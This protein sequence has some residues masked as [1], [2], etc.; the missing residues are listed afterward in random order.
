MPEENS[1]PNRLI[2]GIGISLL[3]AIIIALGGWI[4]H[5]EG[6]FSRL[7]ASQNVVERVS[8]LENAL[9]PVLVEY[10]MREEMKRLGINL[11]TDEEAPAEKPKPSPKPVRGKSRKEIE[12]E[13]REKAREWANQQIQQPVPSH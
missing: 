12:T 8:K 10:R 4:W 9:L 6:R 7:E 11:E 5:S 13:V 1:G 2:M 3:T